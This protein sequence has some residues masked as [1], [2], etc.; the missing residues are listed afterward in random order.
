MVVEGAY[1]KEDHVLNEQVALD[2][3]IDCLVDLLVKYG[4]ESFVE[5]DEAA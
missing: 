4:N 1:Y 3:F 2:S 5:E